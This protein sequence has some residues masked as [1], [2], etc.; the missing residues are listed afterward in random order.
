M[1]SLRM[2]IHKYWPIVKAVASLSKDPKR[3][4]GSIIFDND[5]DVIAS[6]YNG[7]PRGVEDTIERVFDTDVK[8]KMTVHSE[9]NAIT[10]AA[11]LGISTKGR[12][13]MVNLC[14]CFECAKVIIQAGISV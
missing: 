7:L 12:T 13:L 8:L 4:V 1:R 3:K 11:R 10:N 9:V 5:G 6:G 2:P 14:P